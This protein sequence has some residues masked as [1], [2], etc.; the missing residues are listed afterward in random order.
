[1][2]IIIN[3]LWLGV[4]KMAYRPDRDQRTLFDLTKVVRME[5]AS[6]LFTH[7]GIEQIKKQLLDPN[8]PMHDLMRR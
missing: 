6:V 5:Q 7:E 3:W 2:D 8:T 1:L 4:D